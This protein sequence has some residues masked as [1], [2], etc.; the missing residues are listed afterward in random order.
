MWLPGALMTT[1]TKKT[2]LKRLSRKQKTR[3]CLRLVRKTTLRRLKIGSLRVA[4]PSARKTVGTLF[5]GLQ[6]T[7]TKRWLGFLLNITHAPLTFLPPQV[8]HRIVMVLRRRL[9]CN[10]VARKSMI[11]LLSLKMHRRLENTLHLLGLH[12]KA[13][14]KSFGS[15]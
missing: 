2:R 7:V 8:P 10:R 3:C 12:T 9:K 15:C 14:I 4:R 1:M 5:C 6:V 13:I 11:H